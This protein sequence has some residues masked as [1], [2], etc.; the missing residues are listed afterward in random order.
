LGF[1]TTQIDVEL[2]N[3]PLELGYYAGSSE[4]SGLAVPTVSVMGNQA[5]GEDPRRMPLLREPQESE[6]PQSGI[7]N[8]WSRSASMCRGEFAAV[9]YF[10]TIPRSEALEDRAHSALLAPE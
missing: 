10:D 6:R 9:R 1:S 3:S 8:G 4:S 7:A 2:A 5:V